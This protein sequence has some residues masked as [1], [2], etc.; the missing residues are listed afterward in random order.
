MRLRSLR[1]VALGLLVLLATFVGLVLGA[2][3][4]SQSAELLLFS[5]F[6][7]LVVL[8]RMLLVGPSTTKRRQ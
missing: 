6:V 4:A 5:A 3:G 2:V 8:V 7:L 1:L